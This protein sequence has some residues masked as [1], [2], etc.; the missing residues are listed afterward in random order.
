[1]YHGSRIQN[2]I[3]ILSRGLLMPNLVTQLGVTRTVI[4][5]NFFYIIINKF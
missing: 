3:G 2:W 5:F 1:M 4:N